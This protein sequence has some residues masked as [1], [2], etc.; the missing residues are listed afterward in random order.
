MKI[1][2]N[3]PENKNLFKNPVVTIGNFDGVHLGHKKIFNTLLKVAQKTEGDAIVITFSSHPRKVLYPDL[4]IKTITT[5]EEKVDAI[6]NSGISNIILLNFT[7][8]MAQMHA[9]DFFHEIL[10]KQID[11]KELVIGYDHAFG[12]DREGNID[13]LKELTAEYGIGLTQVEEEDFGPRPVSS[14]WL[15]EELENGNIHIVNDLLGRPFSISGTVTKGAGRGRELGFPTANIEI[16]DPDKMLPQNGVYAVEVVLKDIA[17]PGMMN[18]GFNPTFSN[19]KKTIEVNIFDFDRNIYDKPIAVNFIKRIRSEQ[20]F[21]SKDALIKQ[22]KIDKDNTLKV[23][24][25]IPIIK[26]R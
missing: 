20:K 8:E 13:F 4:P 9:K 22:L 5:K 16:E 10:I 11:L 14:S 24:T 25:K 7:K 2:H 18:I 21:K 1:Y 3:I 6:F 17:K 12:K 23:I 15:R 19:D 26:Q